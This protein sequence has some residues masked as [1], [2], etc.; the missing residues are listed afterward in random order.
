MRKNL[1]KT[2]LLIG[3][4][5][6]LS[7]MPGYVMAQSDNDFSKG[8]VLE[9]IGY[10]F[11]EAEAINLRMDLKDT[12]D[13]DDLAR[14]FY[15]TLENAKWLDSI[16]TVNTDKYFKAATFK[17][18]DHTTLEVKMTN[19]IL[20]GVKTIPLL[21]ELT[22]GEAKV[23]IDG[24]GTKF[25]DMNKTTFAIT[26]E[27][28]AEVTV[29]EVP[30][31][32][33]EDNV[34]VIRIDEV[35][36]GSMVDSNRQE[37][38]DITLELLSDHY[39]FENSKPLVTGTRGFTGM[40]S[41]LKEDDRYTQANELI[42]TRYGSFNGKE[43]R[44][45]IK[46][47]LPKRE[48]M[49]APGRLAISELRVKT[50]TFKPETLQ[51]KVS[52]THIN[53]KIVEVAVA[54]E[55]GI[56]ISD[57]ARKIIEIPNGNSEKVSFTIE[58][59]VLESLING[60]TMEITLENGYLASKKKAGISELSLGK[61]LLNNKDITK[62]TTINPVVKGDYLVGFNFD[63]PELDSSIRNKFIIQDLRVYAP[64]A[65]SGDIKVT[66]EVRGGNLK[67][68]TTIAKIKIP[69][70]IQVSPLRLKVGIKDQVGGKLIIKETDKAM[71][72]EGVLELE[73]EEQSGITYGKVPQVKVVEGNLKIGS[74]NYDAIVPN[75]LKINIE[76]S[77][78]KAAT[79]EISGFTVTV[80]NTVPDGH[81]KLSIKGT[82]ISPDVNFGAIEYP[83]FM[84]IG[85]VPVTQEP[86]APQFDQPV[87]TQTSQFVI[88]SKIYLVN[89]APKTMDGAAYIEDNRTMV[90]V[91]Y[92]ADAVG[93]SAE[94]I[95]FKDQII[96]IAAPN[97]TIRLQ[98]GSNMI[99]I[100]GNRQGMSGRAVIK[101]S[102]AYVPIA[103]IAKALGL[104]IEWE[105]KTQTATFKY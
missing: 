5:V 11:T 19:S 37:D 2:L 34:A 25:S 99:E 22:G 82:A 63:I 31:I 74:V 47:S 57:D 52:G 9:K 102:R 92:V 4:V 6:C 94:A 29:G 24:M 45:I 21:V 41:K 3:T 16:N 101:D 39:T 77:S 66:S 100:N 58:E 84:S 72:N 62:T 97:Q 30:S 67:A 87:T 43:D 103:E 1:K 73:I 36:K 59:D 10:Q 14:T 70:Q 44:S 93:I 23:S 89:G 91:R 12:I 54:K 55:Y 83:N 20:A 81:Y 65:A 95:S 27:S 26:S 32:G 71:L 42:S 51:V 28:K 98:V 104:Q 61:L 15:V 49:T 96:T 88:G 38:R 80:D 33:K 56:L 48:N 79:L 86:T 13:Y 7:T 90:P 8:I 17:K 53:D 46:L 105:P 69:A 75:K 40:T 85:N 68:S 78:S 50:N 60:R 76:R 18:V 35:I 64:A